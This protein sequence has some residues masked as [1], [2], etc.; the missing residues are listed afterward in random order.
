MAKELATRMARW[1][2]ELYIVEN[3][4]YHIAGNFCG[5]LIFV[6]DLEITKIS[7]HGN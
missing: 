5:V 3:K 7:I 4:I 2:D 1:V 6:V